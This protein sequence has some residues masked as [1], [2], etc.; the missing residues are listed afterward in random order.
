MLLNILNLFAITITNDT[1]DNSVTD[2]AG[3]PRLGTDRT[4]ASSLIN[5]EEDLQFM[6]TLAPRLLTSMVVQQ[7]MK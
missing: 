5:E 3:R 4:T 7:L 1:A 2:S 6:A